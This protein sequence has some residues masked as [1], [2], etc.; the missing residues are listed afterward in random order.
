MPRR[1]LVLFVSISSALVSVEARADEPSAT[2]AHARVVLDYRAPEGLGC[3]ERDAFAAAIATRL[4][5]DAVDP[6]GDKTLRVSYEKKERAV[7]V[8]LRVVGAEGETIADKTLTSEKGACSDL[9]A[10]AAFAAAILLDPRAM[11][12]RPVAPAPPGGS[13]DSTS[14][15]TSPWYEP[16][17]PEALPPPPP[18][19]PPWKLRVGLSASSCVGCA[20]SAS[21]GGGIVLGTAKGALGIDLGLRATLPVT[22]T[23][24]AGRSL[25]TSLVTGELFPHGRVGPLRLG[26]LGT[27]GSLR[28]ET[29]TETQSSLFAG[30]G[31]RAGLEF[32]LGARAFVGGAIDATVVLA[33]VRLR[34]E[35]RELWST[36]AVAAAVSLGGGF[37]L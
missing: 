26:V 3:L 29:E 27:L 22:E 34:V 12:P 9:G 5:Y 21:F 35:G 8:T 14:P 17:E 11:F 24:A 18:P 7:V 1:A 16:R 10:A 32:P 33:Q 19:S 31:A 37:E 6:N 30:A 28:G 36:P 13:L 15:G 25:R 4:G 2:P 20:P 23:A